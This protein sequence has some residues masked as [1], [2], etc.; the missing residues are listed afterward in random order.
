MQEIWSRKTGDLWTEQRGEIHN[1]V[2]N[3]VQNE[4]LHQMRAN[5]STRRRIPLRVEEIP[6]RTDLGR[7]ETLTRA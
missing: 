3:I 7:L 5:S 4:E 1:L 2:V 6:L